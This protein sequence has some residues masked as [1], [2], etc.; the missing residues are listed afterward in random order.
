MET[1][2]PKKWAYWDIEKNQISKETDPFLDSMNK[3]AEASSKIAERKHQYKEQIAL[4]TKPEQRR[5]AQIR[6]E[7]KLVQEFGNDSEKLGVKF[8]LFPMWCQ[9]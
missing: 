1:N 9:L 5:L 7:A 4:I 2:Y 6:G 8:G 3:A